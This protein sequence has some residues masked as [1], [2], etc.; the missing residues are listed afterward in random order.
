M[1]FE[2]RE[3]VIYGKNPL[4]QVI[5]QIR[6]SPLLVLAAQLPVDLQK[7]L[8]GDYPKLSIAQGVVFQIG[9]PPSSPAPADNTYNF[10][11]EDDV[12]TIALTKD[13]LSLT[14]SRYSRWEEFS[15]RWSVL[16]KSF[17]DVY[18]PISPQRVG[19]RYVDIID[20]EK[21]SL[22]R[23]NWGDWIRPG[24][25]GVLSDLQTADVEQYQ[26][27]SQIRLDEGEGWALLR[28]GLS[29]NIE[30]KQ[31][32][33]MIDADFYADSTCANPVTASVESILD[34][35]GRFNSQAGGLFR[36]SIT[37]YLHAALEPQPI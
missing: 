6:F 32:V 28:T 3:R 2:R 11:S 33:F 19:L 37:D 36:W 26:S 1:R 12:W 14:A 34:R 21:L 4:F 31:P 29:L 16:L 13:S 17:W 8:R 9:N 30:S 25:L 15:H 20:P 23:V 5:C 24:L 7:A 22:A 10:S 18:G 27:F 35:L